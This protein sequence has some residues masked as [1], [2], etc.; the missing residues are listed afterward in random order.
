MLPTQ[1]ARLGSPDRSER[2]CV[3]AR[4]GMVATSV[5]AASAAGV[6]ML[7]RGG[8]AF[9]AAIAA[10]AVLSVVE[11]MQTGIGGDAFAL[12]WS[13]LVSGPL[14][15]GAHVAGAL[16]NVSWIGSAVGGVLWAIWLAP[17]LSATMGFDLR[18]VYIALG[19]LAAVSL[20][21][22]AAL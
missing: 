9:D 18:R 12:F 5:P 8:N 19:L 4:G 20:G 13:A 11:P 10:V 14:A 16:I 15:V 6:E 2:S 7:R 21:M 1:R 22:Q 3:L 17:A